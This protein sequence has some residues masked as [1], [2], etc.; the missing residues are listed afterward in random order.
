MKVSI[1]RLLFLLLLI[2]SLLLNACSQPTPEPTQPPAPTT[3][4]TSTTAPTPESLTLVDGLGKS[5]KLDGPAQR[6]VSL[7]PSNTEILFSIGAGSQIVGRDTFSD[8]PAEAADIPDIGGGFGE[9]NLETILS[10]D[11]DLVLAAEITPTEQVQ[12]LEEVG[13]TVFAMKN[14]KDFDGLYQV[15]QI[16]AQLTAHEDEAATLIEDLK[17]RV[18][19]VTGKAATSSFHPLV[20]YELDSTDPSAPWTSGGGTFIDT[21]IT[22]AGGANLGATLEGEWVQISIEELLTQNPDLIILGDYTWGGVTPEDV[23]ARSGWET[24]SAVKDGQV[25][26]IDDNLV[27]R[28]GP[29]LVDGLEAMAKLL[30]P[31]LFN[32]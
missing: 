19:A 26:T 15:I 32:N 25:F 16:A 2:S 22:M 20:F 12:A 5:I 21:L 30:H 29:R 10:S 24:L 4:P 9:L 31:E 27:S 13:L 17:G 3:Q 18:D 23:A 28:P 6:I 8:Y 11:P 14:P 1:I 7:A